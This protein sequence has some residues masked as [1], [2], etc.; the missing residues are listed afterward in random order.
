MLARALSKCCF[1]RLISMLEPGP[2]SKF[3]KRNSFSTKKLIFTIIFTTPL[4]LSLL[5]EVASKVLQFIVENTTCIRKMLYLS[6]FWWKITNKTDKLTKQVVGRRREAISFENKSSLML[7]KV[8][9]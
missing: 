9:C 5:H 8:C 4:I 2:G 7:L 6:R 3:A 1:E